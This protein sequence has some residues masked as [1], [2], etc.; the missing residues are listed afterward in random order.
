MHR[1][2]RIIFLSYFVLLSPVFAYVVDQDVSDVQLL[3]HCE[4]FFDA[5]NCLSLEDVKNKTFTKNT[6]SV[7]N[8]GI[9]PDKRLWIRCELENNTSKSIAKLLEYANQETEDI[10]FFDGVKKIHEGMFYHTKDRI[11]L[12]PTFKISLKPFE[13]RIFYI[14]AYCKIS[15]FVAKFTLWNYEEY[16]DYDASKKIYILIFFIIISTLLLYNI[17]LYFFIREKVYLYYILYITAVIIF[18]SIYLG[19][20]QLYFFPNWLSCLVTKATMG[21]VVMLVVPMLLFTMEFLQTSRFQKIDFILKSYLYILPIV[22]LL[23]YNNL[24]FDLNIMLIF[25]PLACV[26]IFAGFVAYKNGTTEALIYLFGWTFVIVSLV[27]SIV[28]SLGWYNVFEL[29]NNVNEVAFASE[30]FIF[31]IALAYQI[32]RLNIQLAQFQEDEQRKLALMVESKTEELQHYFAEKELLY[33][34]LQHRVKNNFAMVISLIDLQIQNSKVTK[35]KYEL[36][37]IRNRINS[38][39]KLYELLHFSNNKIIFSTKHYFNQIVKNISKNFKK[40]VDI[41]YKIDYEISVDKSIYC[42]L[43]IN[44]LVTNSFKYAFNDDGVIA[45]LAYLDK[46]GMVCLCIEDNGVGFDINCTH[47]LGLTI[48]KTLAVKQLKANIDMKTKNGV[49]VTIKWRE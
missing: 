7:L 6:K 49:K 4:T 11:F 20:A 31:S 24:V 28:Q 45:I 22:A 30:T 18:E 23:S 48:V 42:G 40:N 13:K 34:E 12:N 33:K 10:W 32:K 44:E 41:I 47:S 25:F 15:T 29:F 27:L 39:V 37:T 46:E 19:V 36:S 21:Y 35:V 38:F 3:P 16:K 8:F 9:M 26:M 5:K 2:V 17:I 1:A 14:K 43:I